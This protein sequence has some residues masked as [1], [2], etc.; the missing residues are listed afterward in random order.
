MFVHL[1]PSQNSLAGMVSVALDFLLESASGSRG[2]TSVG[3]FEPAKYFVKPR[4]NVVL[5]CG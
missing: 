1:A 3:P 2:E 4:I 5:M